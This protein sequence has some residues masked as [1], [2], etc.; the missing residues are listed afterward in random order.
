MARAVDDEDAGRAVQ[1]LRREVRRLLVMTA[2]LLALTLVLLV[3]VFAWRV[4]G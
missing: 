2:V 4:P 3:T 1:G